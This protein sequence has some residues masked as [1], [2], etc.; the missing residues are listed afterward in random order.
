MT[1]IMALDDTFD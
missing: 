1:Y